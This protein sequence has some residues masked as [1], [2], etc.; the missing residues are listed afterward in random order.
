MRTITMNHCPDSCPIASRLMHTLSS[1]IVYYRR[2][3]RLATL[4]VYCFSQIWSLARSIAYSSA[5]V[6]LGS[7]SWANTHHL[8]VVLATD[9][10]VSNTFFV[11]DS[12]SSFHRIVSLSWT[13]PL[14]LI[15]AIGSLHALLSFF[16]CL[17]ESG[18]LT[19][20]PHSVHIAY[21]QCPPFSFIRHMG[22]HFIYL[23]LFVASTFP[24]GA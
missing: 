10:T 4:F 11:R 2:R 1:P 17:F 19:Y 12:R 14:A 16:F 5:L 24:G 22:G 7:M 21:S 13:L 6:R 3:P 15:I 8:L 18:A 9:D 20:M 23:H